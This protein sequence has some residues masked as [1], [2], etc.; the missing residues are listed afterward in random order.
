MECKD[1]EQLL[2][3]WLDGELEPGQAG[4]LESHLEDCPSCGE[5]ARQMRRL[6]E[7]MDDAMPLPAPENLSART[8][9]AFRRESGS[10]SLGN[11]WRGLSLGM[12]GA[13]CG[14]AAAGLILGLIMAGTLS[15]LIEVNPYYTQLAALDSGGVWQ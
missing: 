10:L 11:W 13:A 7:A 2:S 6:A 15:N 14:L 3:P 12:R 9:D 1:A 8:L 5:A 4:M